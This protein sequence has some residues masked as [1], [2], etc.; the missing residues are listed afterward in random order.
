MAALVKM[1]I[2]L[3]SFHKH[4]YFF[5]FCVLSILKFLFFALEYCW[6][7]NLFGGGND[8]DYYHAYALGLDI[9][10][11]NIWPVLLRWLND[12]GLYSRELVAVF[13]KFI[14]ILVIPLLVARLA[15]VKDSPLYGK[16]FWMLACIVSAYPT[17]VYLATDIYRDVFMVFVWCVGLFVLRQ[18]FEVRQVSLKFICFIL[19]LGFSWMLFEFRPYLGLGYL[20]ALLFSGCYRF[21][22]YPVWATM[23]IWPAGL[24]ALYI[25]GILEPI[26][27]YRSMFHDGTLQGGSNIGIEFSSVYSFVP[28]F[29][30]SLLYQITGFYFVNWL[31]VVAF[32]CESILFLLAL[33]YVLRNKRY[34]DKFVNCLLVF[35]IVY[36]SVWLLGNDNMGTATRLRVFNYISVYI[37]FFIIWQRKFKSDLVLSLGSAG[38]VQKTV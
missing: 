16:A 32:V 21:S 22:K 38:K 27:S 7:A 17:L 9:V 14:V 25:L 5:C 3:F 1:D 31:S 8:S 12:V 13:L 11:V 26:L 24:F 18:M 2:L 37:A 4:V 20:G 29:F 15:Y 33:F 23:L 36:A 30:R 34:A 6:G 19:G 35:F 10:A 28:D